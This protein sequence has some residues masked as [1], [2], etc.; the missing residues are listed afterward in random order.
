MRHIEITPLKATPAPSP[1]LPTLAPVPRAPRRVDRAAP[2][3]ITVYGSW[4]SSVRWGRVFVVALVVGLAYLWYRLRDATRQLEARSSAAAGGVPPPSGGRMDDPAPLRASAAEGQRFG[5]QRVDAETTGQSSVGEGAGGNKA[6]GRDEDDSEGEGNAS[7]QPRGGAAFLVAWEDEAPPRKGDRL[8]IT[9]TSSLETYA[10]DPSA[11]AGRPVRLQPPPEVWSVAEAISASGAKATCASDDTQRIR[12]GR[13]P[14]A[15]ILAPA[16]GE[17]PDGRVRF[18]GSRRLPLP[19][20]GALTRIRPLRRAPSNARQRAQTA[21]AYQ[22]R[23]PAFALTASSTRCAWARSSS[24]SRRSFAQ[25]CASDADASACFRSAWANDRSALS[26]EISFSFACASCSIIV[27]IPCI[28]CMM[29]SA[30]DLS[31]CLSAV[32]ALHRERI[33][34]MSSGDG[35]GSL[36]ASSEEGREEVERG[37]GLPRRSRR[38]KRQARPRRRVRQQHLAHP[39]ARRQLPDTR[40]QQKRHLSVA[41]PVCERRAAPFVAGSDLARRGGVLHKQVCVRVHEQLS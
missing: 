32:S 4:W 21:A 28:S 22:R 26:L 41:G 25:S 18:H 34:S 36:F 15:I 39:C 40:V 16:R 30:T 10:C 12:M 20:V 37:T 7:S 29:P 31:T 17:T 11:F 9:D 35:A 14:Q 2:K 24:T 27:S 13:A 1:P 6:E 19:G 5:E 33:A 8:R 23:L 3:T 38:E